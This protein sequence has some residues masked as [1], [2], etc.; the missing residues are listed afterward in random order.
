MKAH[1]HKLVVAFVAVAAMSTS[2]LADA[3]PTGTPPEASRRGSIAR[4]LMLKQRMEKMANGTLASSL[5][6]NRK[7]WESLAP[8]QREHYR[9]EALAFLKA[10]PAQQQKLV[11]HYEKFARVSAE[12]RRKY[13]ET[14]RWVKA[15]V[16]TL[17]DTERKE[18]LEMS[19]MQRARF[20][21]AQ[22]LELIRQGKLPP[23]TQPAV[24]APAEAPTAP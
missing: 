23:A 1:L 11:E 14:A 19:P 9:N 4:Q 13:R 10:N 17:S 18:L 5:E 3:E 15:V 12:K 21:R 8:E 24:T 2:V 22:R 6:H 7:Q 20:L 16:A